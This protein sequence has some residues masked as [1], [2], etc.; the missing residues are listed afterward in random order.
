MQPAQKVDRLPYRCRHGDFL[1][2]V[3]RSGRDRP[4][5]LVPRASAY[6]D[7]PARLVGV[8]VV[9]AQ[10]HGR[11]R[12]WRLLRQRFEWGRMVLRRGQRW[13]FLRRRQRRQLLTAD[14]VASP[15]SA[16]ARSTVPRP[17]WAAPSRHRPAPAPHRAERSALIQTVSVGEQ[18]P[19]CSGGVPVRE[20]GDPAGKRALGP[21]PGEVVQRDPGFVVVV[22]P[23]DGC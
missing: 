22:H 14:G 10:R 3:R 12:R 13:R 16:T 1:R 7:D 17:A 15:S 19:T 20:V 6:A 4:H 8:R 21:G 2:A 9:G 18:L 11:R 23:F 5:L